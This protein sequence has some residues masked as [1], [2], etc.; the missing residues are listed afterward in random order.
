MCDTALRLWLRSRAGEEVSGDSIGARST[1]QNPW[2]AAKRHLDGAQPICVRAVVVVMAAI[3]FPASAVAVNPSLSGSLMVPFA[4]MPD[5]P[6]VEGNQ[7]YWYWTQGISGGINLSVPAVLDITTSVLGNLNWG[8]PNNWN[9]FPLDT[10]GLF[11][12]ASGSGTYSASVNGGSPYLN[13]L[14]LAGP[15]EGSVATQVVFTNIDGSGGV[16]ESGSAIIASNIEAT[17]YNASIPSGAHMH[18]DQIPTLQ[19]LT[20]H[21][22]ASV[23]NGGFSIT[24]RDNF[25]NHGSGDFNALVGGDFTNDAVAASGNVANSTYLQISGQLHN[26]GELNVPFFLKTLAP[27]SNA[28]T[29]KINGGD[30]NAAAAFTNSGTI[31]FSKGNIYGPGDITNT[32]TFQWV[33]EGA[34]RP[35]AQVINTTSAFTIVGPDTNSRT[36]EGTLINKATITQSGGSNLDTSGA[37]NNEAGAL[38]DI[39][40]DSHVSRDAVHGTINNAGTFR[41]SG[42]SGNS[43]V[44]AALNNTGTVA[45]TSGKLR[46]RAGGTLNGGTMAFAGGHEVEFYAGNFSVVGTNSASGNGALEISDGHVFADTGNSGAF[47]NFT[48]GAN[49]LLTGGLVEGKTGGTLTF[50]LNGTSKVQL[51]GNPSAAGG[52]VGGLGS[53]I[54]LG[55]FEWVHGTVAGS[56]TNNSTN[57]AITAGEQRID[58]AGLL[59][60]TSTITQGDGGNMSLGGTIANQSGAV[61]LSTGTNSISNSSPTPVVNNAGTWRKTGA[62]TI[63]SLH[64]IAFNNTGTLAIDSGELFIIGANVLNLTPAGTLSFKLGGLI[65]QVDFGVLEGTN[66][67]T[68]GG[69]L[70]VTLAA[71]FAPALGNAFDLVDTCGSCSLGGTF[72]KLALPPLAAGLKWDASQLYTSGVLSVGA[73]LLGDFNQNGVVDAPDYVIWRE[74]LGTTYT[75]TDFNIW[76]A[77]FGETASSGAAAA[78]QVTVPEPAVGLLLIAWLPLIARRRLLAG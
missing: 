9:K 65:P 24:V 37:I 68:L 25:V 16:V 50:N 63:S 14:G 54:N 23:D 46:F 43:E 48:G 56:F 32:G 15:T 12:S 57:F 75:Q 67:L 3:A 5:D 60:N 7:S 61:W 28:G 11:I 55:N 44:A 18:F 72:T 36:L 52:S 20:I 70:T 53:T 51:T 74:Y 41:K 62:S 17:K 1:A 39:I 49:L 59:T 38:Y 73:G 19:N 58:N 13:V 64:S 31:R 22:G 69:T 71:G 77:H 47:A 21:S 35:G 34:I 29:L 66:S 45:V 76:R 40:D 2:I 42:G 30:F 6:N 4:F 78:I 26:T 8:N 33:D 10:G 27:T